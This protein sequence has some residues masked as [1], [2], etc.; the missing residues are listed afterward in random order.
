MTHLQIVWITAAVVIASSCGGVCLGQTKAEQRRENLALLNNARNK[1]AAAKRSLQDAKADAT[2]LQ[3][4]LPGAEKAY[5]A[6]EARYKST[7]AKETEIMNGLKAEFENDPRPIAARRR[8]NEAQEAERKLRDQLMP[9]VKGSEEYNV[10]KSE[11]EAIEKK[12]VTLREASPVNGEAVAA[13]AQEMMDAKRMLD[14]IEV[15]LLR[16]NFAY[17]EASDELKAARAEWGELEREISGR[18]DSDPER[19]IAAQKAGTA[20]TD[21]GAK[22]RV[23]EDTR[24]GLSIAQSR[25]R[26]AQQAVSNA[27]RDIRVYENKLGIKKGGKKNNKKK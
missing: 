16:K 15:E 20:R 10:R 21:Y 25:G 2:R 3:K 6:S 23:W 13:A 22:R 12:L 26:A 8:L 14:D 19:M 17:R 27:E 11:A 4:Q 18:I 1:L 5:R 24:R 7:K 9:K